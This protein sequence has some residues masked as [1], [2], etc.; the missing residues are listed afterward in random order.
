MNDQCPLPYQ[1]KCVQPDCPWWI[2]KHCTIRAILTAFN[3]DKCKERYTIYQ[4]RIFNNYEHEPAL[5]TI[6]LL[7]DT[8][9][10]HAGTWIEPPDTIIE[11]FIPILVGQ[12][13]SEEEHAYWMTDG[14][15]V[16]MSGDPTGW[17]EWIEKL[18]AWQQGRLET[19]AHAQKALKE[20]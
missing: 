19:L 15:K 5:D 4:K 9:I 2:V 6:V 7:N 17:K 20:R 12:V 8:V 16:D 13:F 3:A 10:I 14:K 11:N 18:R 1:E